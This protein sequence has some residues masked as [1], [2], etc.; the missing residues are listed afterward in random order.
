MKLLLTV[1]AHHDPQRLFRAVQSAVNAEPSTLFEHEVHVVLNSLHEDWPRHMKRVLKRRWP[2]VVVH[3]T[4]SNGLPGK[5]KNSCLRLAK[6]DT[7]CDYIVQLDGDDFFYP[8]VLRSIEWHLKRLPGLDCLSTIPVE[9]IA[10]APPKG[11]TFQVQE[12]VWAGIWGNNSQWP[13]AEPAGRNP[14]PMWR[15]RLPICPARP[16]LFS[17]RIACEHAFSETLRVGEDHLLLC[18]LL[19]RYKREGI[20]MANTMAIDMWC[21][22]RTGTGSVQQQFSQ[23]PEVLPLKKAAMAHLAY[24]ESSISE[25]PMLFPPTLMALKARETFIRRQYSC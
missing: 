17:R 19:A 6:R 23:L 22:D 3:I 2:E 4:K 21:C 11:Y 7:S 15:E 8:T 18:E 13:L 25:L 14:S 20:C 5:G 12:G 1:L 16:L 24:N 10:A 9:L